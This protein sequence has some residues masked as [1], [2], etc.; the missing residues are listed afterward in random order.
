MTAGP[1]TGAA[2]SPG[3]ADPGSSGFQLHVA[4]SR[5]G[6]GVMID[7]RNVAQKSLSP[8]G[9]ISTDGLEVLGRMVRSRG[10]R[11]NSAP[12]RNLLRAAAGPPLACGGAQ[13]CRLLLLHLRPR[14]S[15]VPDPDLRHRLQH[16]VGQQRPLL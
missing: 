7:C 13:S 12:V 5:S 11:N 14:V 6:A 15:P 10:N 4:V 9:N 8:A 16:L 3:A 2:G 1:V